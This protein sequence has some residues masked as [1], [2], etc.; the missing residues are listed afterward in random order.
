MVKFFNKVI[1][2]A[3]ILSFFLQPFLYAKADFLCVNTSDFKYLYKKTDDNYTAVTSQEIV[4]LKEE[5]NQLLKNFEDAVSVNVETSDTFKINNAK[6]YEK[7]KISDFVV[8][9]FTQSKY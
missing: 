9:L 1:M 5:I 4:V 8:Q 7:T 3:I 6:A 2:F